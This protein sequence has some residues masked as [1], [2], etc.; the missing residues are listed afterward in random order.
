MIL[1]VYSKTFLDS[2]FES[3]DESLMLEGYN[4]IQSDHPNNT[5]RGGVCIYYKKSLSVRL[6]YITFLHENLI[7]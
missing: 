1:Y 5:K 2:S 6:V 3:D 4:S 7:C